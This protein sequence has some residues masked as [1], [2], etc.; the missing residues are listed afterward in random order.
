MS[1]PNKAE[2]EQQRGQQIAENQ[3]GRATGTQDEFMQMLRDQ[4]A[5]RGGTSDPLMAK[6]A[7]MLPGLFDLAKSPLDIGTPEGLSPEAMAALKAQAIEGVP[8]HFDQASQRLKAQLA[9]RGL[10]GG[11]GTSGLVAG[12]LGG[13]EI[14]KEQERASG[15]RNVTLAD[16]AARKADLESRRSLALNTRQLALSGMTGGFGAGS[17]LIAKMLQSTDF[18]PFISGASNALGE[19][20]QATANRTSPT[21]VLRDPNKPE[22]MWRTFGKAAI[23]SGLG[24]ASKRLGG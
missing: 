8:A 22:S 14:A 24:L 15:L 1:K 11:S 23:G 12:P 17:D 10:A 3:I 6:L 18:A 19:A 5:K 4:M 2:P 21:L 16:E 7:E 20:G 9:R 13:L